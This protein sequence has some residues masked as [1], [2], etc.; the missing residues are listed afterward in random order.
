MSGP[1]TNAGP[2]AATAVDHRPARTGRR[3][4]ESGARDAILAAARTEFAAGGYG[5]ATI[6][7]I[8]A[9]A[10]VD[11]ALVHHYFGTKEQLFETALELPVSPAT[12][13]PALL[14][15]DR[16]HIGEQVVLR[17]LTVWEEPTNR[18]I[19]LAMLRSIVSNEQAAEL[20]RRLLVKEVFGPLATALGVPDAELR[21]TLAGS[22]FIGLAL[23][24]YVGRVE[25]LAST[26]LA[27]VAAA[28]GPTIQ[29]YLTGAI[30]PAAVDDATGHSTEDASGGRTAAARRHPSPL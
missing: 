11:P 20:V 23:M 26:D 14:A 3:P 16:D 28:V 1:A 19:F 25:P 30:R 2:A 8:A 21:A 24:R 13:L 15:D 10:G 4:G 27:T 22:Q 29:R 9:R 6:R 12:L 7:G 5:G 17:F 18:P